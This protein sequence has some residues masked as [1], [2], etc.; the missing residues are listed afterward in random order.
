MTP[1]RKKTVIG[2]VFVG[3][4]NLCLYGF[5]LSQSFVTFD[6]DLHLTAN[7]W[8]QPFT[9]KSLIYFWTQSYENLYIPVSYTAWGV[10]ART[11]TAFASTSVLS[12][13][14]FKLANLVL[15]GTNCSLV[16][17]ILRRLKYKQ[18]ASLAGTVLFAIHPLQVE[19]VA[20]ISEFRGLLAASFGFSA[21]FIL[22]RAL[23]AEHADVKSG[24]STRTLLISTT[25]LSAAMLAKPSAASFV[26][27]GAVLC[28][29]I[30]GHSIFQTANFAAIWAIPVLVSTY[31]SHI[32]QDGTHTSSQVH[33]LQRI[34]VASDS[35]AFYLYKFVIPTSLCMDYGRTPQVVL[36]NSY[37]M[38]SV[39]VPL[40]LIVVLLWQRQR[41]LV[42]GTCLTI[43]GLAPTLGL[44]SFGFQEISTVA[45]RYCY[46]AMFGIAYLIA[47]SWERF[48]F[49][50]WRVLNLGAA[51]LLMFLTFQQIQVWKESESLYTHALGI[52]PDSWLSLNNLGNLEADAGNY[53]TALEYFNEA[54][55]LRPDY[56]I[57]C[58]NIG[59]CLKELGQD[60]EALVYFTRAVELTPNCVSCQWSLGTILFQKGDYQRAK[61]CFSAATALEN[62]N[63]ELCSD[64]GQS[65]LALNEFQGAVKAYENVLKLNPNNLDAKSRLGDRYLELGLLALAER[66]YRDALSIEHDLPPVH[67]NCG[68]IQ[69]QKG[70][71][72]SAARHF[73]S[74]LSSKQSRLNPELNHSARLELI[75][76]LL[77][78]GLKANEANR[79]QEALKIF[80][81]VLTLEPD[82]AAGHFQLARVLIATH[83]HSEAIRHLNIVLTLVPD[84][85]VAAK[86][87]KDL[88]KQL[89]LRAMKEVEP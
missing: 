41:D 84:D 15:H 24:L 77:S 39:L 50:T 61:D 78:L 17:L 70:E 4:L 56:G 87:T 40:V 62:D 8:M 51:C 52:N 27:F 54:L 3:L 5:I 9:F 81:E 1:E 2:L 7:R 64:Y 57:A 10:L 71:L 72:E 63:P 36:Q 59:V 44:V 38:W 6:D 28:W 58:R 80:N 37:S 86:D 34:T 47:W 60:D 49:A 46:L 45:D 18:A 76:I 33:W 30:A 43:G 85:S 74:V 19:S 48:Q 25:L 16:Y 23:T 11:T 20:W 22:V 31:V 67:F 89:E 32:L 12:P 14:V 66:Y 26:L 68:L 42:I 79:P 75:S 88:L 73:R 13:A 55:Q 82:H 35:L 29:G 21:L 83:N 65:L 69:A 53:D